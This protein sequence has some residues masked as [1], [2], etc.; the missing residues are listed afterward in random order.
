[1][2]TK[3][4]KLASALDQKGLFKEADEIDDAMKIMA[5]RAGV[6]IEQLTSLADELDQEGLVDLANAIDALVKEAKGKVKYWK[7]KD[8]KPPVR[9]DVKK[10][11]KP[12]FAEKKKELKKKNPDYSD[13]RISAIIGNLWFNTMSDAQRDKIWKSMGRKGKA[14]K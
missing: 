9:H 11:P 3:L 13:K 7:G 6:N 8:Q 4:Y 12:F 10:V 1:M 5:D 2:L 14:E